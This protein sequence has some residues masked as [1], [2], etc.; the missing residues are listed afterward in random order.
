[1][2]FAH[3][4]S[5]LARLWLLYQGFLFIAVMMYFPEGIAGVGDRIFRSLKTDSRGE[6]LRMAVQ[7][8]AILCLL[9]AAIFILELFGATFGADPG[10]GASTAAKVVKTAKIWGMNVEVMSLW[11]WLAP[12]AILALSLAVLRVAPR[13]RH[14]PRVRHAPPVT[15]ET[16]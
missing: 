1:M 14:A 9:V 13:A 11:T 2:C 10:R 15:G 8:P 7:A 12:A 4:F 3:I 16:A 5:D 6:F